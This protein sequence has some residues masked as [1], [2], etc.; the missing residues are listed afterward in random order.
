MDAQQTTRSLRHF[1]KY[2]FLVS[3]AHNERKQTRA[4]VYEHLEKMRKSILRMNLSYTDIDRLK[5][6]IDKLADSERKYSRFFRPE[7]SEKQDMKSRVVALE[8]E[9]S[10][11]KE[12]KFKIMG[13]HEARI[14]EMKD[15]LDGVKHKLRTLM[16]EKAKRHH[17]LKALEE[18]ISQ[19]VDSREF[20][21]P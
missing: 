20:F 19:R 11:E 10:R 6:K 4:E 3:K 1:T 21:K 16:V 15:S 9:L 2:L 5:E 7:D 12:E 13:E 18:K 14:K 17:R 8:G